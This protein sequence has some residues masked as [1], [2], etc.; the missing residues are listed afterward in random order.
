[1]PRTTTPRFL[2]VQGA[3]QVNQLGAVV[4]C[5]LLPVDTLCLN[6][7][8]AA[9]C[10]ER[11]LDQP[12]Q[13]KKSQ[14]G[15]RAT[16]DD[17]HTCISHVQVVLTCSTFDL[18]RMDSMVMD[19]RNPVP[20]GVSVVSWTKVCCWWHN[21]LIDIARRLHIVNNYRNNS[22]GT[23]IYMHTL[24]LCYACTRHLIPGTRYKLPTD[25]P[26]RV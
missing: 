23:G 2:A 21:L 25:L 4:C 12:L 13:K 24:V 10:R 5:C 26:H 14:R 11:L 20:P 9:I 8:P 17:V 7:N 15:E 16:S 22:T 1:M 18:Q 3:W 19:K 6:T